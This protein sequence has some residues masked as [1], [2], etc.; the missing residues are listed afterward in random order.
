[1]SPGICGFGWRPEWWRTSVHQLL[2]LE[3][4]L[5]S[6]EVRGLSH[7][8]SCLPMYRSCRIL[9]ASCS[10]WPCSGQG[11]SEWQPAMSAVRSIDAEHGYHAAG[12]KVIYELQEHVAL[13]RGRWIMPSL[14]THLSRGLKAM[15][16]V[17]TSYLQAPSHSVS[18]TLSGGKWGKANVSY[19]SAEKDRKKKGMGLCSSSYSQLVPLW[20]L[21]LE[22]QR[23]WLPHGHGQFVGMGGLKGSVLELRVPLFLQVPPGSNGEMSWEGHEPPGEEQLLC[24]IQL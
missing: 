6:W 20:W 18:R 21:F 2:W 1:M 17:G 4:R 11:S 12:A 3:T 5:S 24:L 7:P 9:H 19:F 16:V 10:R 14:H 8:P 23:E 15:E 22:R 13:V